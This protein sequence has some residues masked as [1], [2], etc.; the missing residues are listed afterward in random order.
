MS[1]KVERIGFVGLG[2]QGGPMA[3]AIAV[4]SGFELHMWARRPASQS[5]VAEVPHVAHDMPVGLAGS[6]ELS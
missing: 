6:V 1:K 5:A 4:D 2:D 3:R